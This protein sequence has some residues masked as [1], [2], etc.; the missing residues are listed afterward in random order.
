MFTKGKWEVHDDGIGLFGYVV[1]VN[2]N[3]KY[4]IQISAALTK[5][6]ETPHYDGIENIYPQKLEAEANAKLIA[7]SPLLLEACK[8][9]M[10][11][12]STSNP[13][14]MEIST[15]GFERCYQAIAKATN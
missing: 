2:L 13:D 9:I 1:G 8:A 11:A 12:E 14:V 6:K 4:E 15:K 7:A 3:T 10:Q 5:T